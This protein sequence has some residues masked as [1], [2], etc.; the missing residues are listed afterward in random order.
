MVMIDACISI[1]ML[2]V[3]GLYSLLSILMTILY[4][5]VWHMCH[6]GI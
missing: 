3:D 6:F 1:Y 5:S 2:I 4:V